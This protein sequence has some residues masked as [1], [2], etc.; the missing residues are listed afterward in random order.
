M[1]RKQSDYLAALLADEP[2][3]TEHGT[4]AD[5]ERRADADERRAE[6]RAVR[7]GQS[8]RL[9]RRRQQGIASRAAHEHVERAFIG[10]GHRGTSRTTVVPDPGAE[11][12]RA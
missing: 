8:P 3:E 12:R 5:D 10:K 7:H 2:A 4:D 9:G 1:A 6:A 11:K